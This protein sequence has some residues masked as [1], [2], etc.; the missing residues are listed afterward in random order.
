MAGLVGWLA[1]GTPGSERIHP[2]E[3]KVIIPGGDSRI[4]ETSEPQATGLSLS[5]P[6]SRM[7]SS[8]LIAILKVKKLH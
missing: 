2:K 5:N 3:G 1:T 8:V 4:P 7:E 6:R